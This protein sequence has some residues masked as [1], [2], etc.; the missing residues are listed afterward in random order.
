MNDRLVVEPILKR[1]KDFQRR[2]VEY[3]FERMFL[4]GDPAYRF[5]VADEVGLGKT[6]VARGVIAKT[7]RHLQPTVSRI[8]IVY[9]CSNAAIANQ[10]LNR[11][12]VYG[13]QQFAL[14]TRLTLLPTRISGLRSN[15][16]NFISF[17]PGTTFEFGNRGG[18][19]EE[20]RVLYHM[21]RDRF[22]L[23]R[24]G[25]LNLLQATAFK[26]NWR[27]YAQQEVILDAELERLFVREL[28]CKPA[29]LRELRAVD[30]VFYTFR[31]NVP[32]E[33]FNRSLQVISGLR[34]LL[35]KVCIGALEPDL[36]ILDE[37]Q[38]FKDLLNGDSE[39]ALLAQ[40]LFEYSETDGEGRERR[41][42]VLLLSATPY[43]MYTLNHETEDDH[44]ADFLNTLRFLFRDDSVIATVERN[45]EQFRRALHGGGQYSAVDV[46]TARNTLQDLL[47]RVMVRT[48]R[49]GATDRRDAMLSEPAV[50]TE[51]RAEDLKQAI[52]VDHVSRNLEVSDSIEYWKSS[53]YLLNLMKGYELKRA[54]S[55]KAER[56]S[57]ELLDVLGK[58]AGQ[59]L[60]R[61]QFE[62]YRELEPANARLRALLKD[63]VEAGQWQ[64][65]WVPPS[66]P[67]WQPQGAYADQASMTKALVFSSWQVV[68]DAIASLCSYEAER[69][70]LI[71][72]ADRPRYSALTR[73]R[74]PLLRFSSNAE[75][76]LSGMPVLGLVYPC[77]TLARL[78]D[79]IEIALE[80]KSQ[81]LP[82]LDEV[83]LVAQK[84]IEQLLQNTGRW[85]GASEGR[86]DQR[87]YWAA[88]ALLDAQHSPWMRAWCVSNEEDGWKRVSTDPDEEPASGFATHVAR[89]VEFFDTNAE[90]GCP[91][92]NLPEVLAEIALAGPAVCSMRSMRRVVRWAEWDESAL[93]NAAA[94][95]G[96]GFRSLFNLPE[97]ISFLRA[98]DGDAPYWRLA[99]QYGAVGNLSSVLDEYFHWLLESLGLTDLDPAEAV[100]QIGKTA[101]DA[102]SVHTSRIQLDQLRVWPRRGSIS[103]D[104]FNLRSRFA[105]RFGNLRS[106]QDEQV[107]RTETVQRAFN[108]PFRPFI[109]ATTSI[110]QEGLDFHPYCHVVYHWNLPSNPVELEQREGRIHRYKGHAIRKNIASN[111]GLDKL[112][113]NYQRGG[114]AWAELFEVAAREREPGKGDLIPYWIYP[115]ENGATVERRV[116]MLPFSR[117]QQRLPDLKASLAV[118][119]LVFGQ[120]RQEDL[121]SHLKERDPDALSAWRLD[122]SPP[123]SQVQ[124]PMLGPQLYDNNQGVKLVCRRC[125]DE[126]GHS[127]VADGG[128]KSGQLHWQAGD[129]VMLFYGSPK[130]GGPKF[131]PGKALLVNDDCVEV[132]FSQEAR[133]LQFR[134]GNVFW[135]PKQKEHCRLVS[136]VDLSGGEEIALVCSTCG[137]HRQHRCRVNGP[138]LLPFGIGALV[139]V[140]YD[141]IPG[142][143]AGTFPAVVVR[144]SGRVAR[145]QCDYGG[146]ETEVVH[147]YLPSDG[148]WFDLDYAVPCGVVLA[149]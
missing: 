147:L 64:L 73:E 138:A 6:M 23:S 20:R 4:D 31:K 149:G 130:N 115:V 63:T 119:R 112:R 116:P 74:K 85:P 114:D 39:A 55:T 94:C 135:D 143:D 7:I 80:L 87:W 67:Y 90:L 62:H 48:E 40:A 144:A 69:R 53:P 25:L 70:M 107:A 35:A 36:I 88:L 51:L 76:R 27:H 133:N 110:G 57:Q 106:D 8:D 47:K 84:K 59:L 142:L 72:D 15:R 45:L 11:L 43:K 56:P 120:P 68:P 128:G 139:S 18:S 16:I 21:L 42:R 122:L 96:E 109:L 10:N 146:G 126:V 137:Q 136:H 54:M 140:T 30:E 124:V 123:V 79:P 95:V 24:T 26:D 77:A 145:V 58:G 3:V 131:C 134:G 102:V 41:P 129:R 28:R 82:S 148:A 17:T 44:Y 98:S 19:K 13:N 65:L 91:P 141:P 5:L 38:R 97:T 118:Y 105:M 50:K 1:L 108:S 12:N 89:F 46:E 29:L 111:L 93:C 49:V 22:D 81:G 2:T 66:L 83:K 34:R 9:V 92:A 61:N 71:A 60:R 52:F 132:Q 127:C 75:E 104:P 78:I 32:K 14:A 125:G 100:R 103:L 99:L 33:E 121:L 86:E 113:G 117:E 101:A 37:F